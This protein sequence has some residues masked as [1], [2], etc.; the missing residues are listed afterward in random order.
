MFL[1]WQ[2]Q[3]DNDLYKILS[4]RGIDMNNATRS[5]VLGGETAIWSEQTDS[6][7]IMGKIFPRASSYAERLW[8]NPETGWYEAEPRILMHRD[9]LVERGV[10]AD[11]LQ[12]GKKIN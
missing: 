3:Y 5:L 7:S 9:R 12:P 4:D 6:Y 2:L 1:G 11:A 8:T 10:M